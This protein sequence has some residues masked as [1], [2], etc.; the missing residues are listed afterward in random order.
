MAETPTAGTSNLTTGTHGF[1]LALS[2]PYPL[3][4]TSCSESTATH[5]GPFPCG[6]ASGP[7][8][9]TVPDRSRP[10][11]GT[12][13]KGAG[14]AWIV[15]P[16]FFITYRPGLWAVPLIQQTTGRR[17]RFPAC[18]VELA[19]R[20]RTGPARTMAACGPRLA[21]D[22]WRRL[23]CFSGHG[24][25]G[26]LSHMPRPPDAG[27]DRL[28]ELWGCAVFWALPSSPRGGLS[29]SAAHLQATRH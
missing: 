17:P 15:G 14:P 13:R 20:R 22:P 9:L 27:H 6:A 5:P 12:L 23:P 11:E 25:M 18:A 29:W 21:A 16:L 28:P 8:G 2:D 26:R 10:I 19:E 7:V 1:C 24:G 4:R 3:P